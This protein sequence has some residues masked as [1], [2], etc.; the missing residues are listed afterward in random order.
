MATGPILRNSESGSP[1]DE[2]G[3]PDMAETEIDA[4]TPML[5]VDLMTPTPPDNQLGMESYERHA[6]KLNIPS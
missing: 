3:H 1:L 2:S 5:D 6:S 4:T